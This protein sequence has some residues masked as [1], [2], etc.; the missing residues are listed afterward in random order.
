MSSACTQVRVSVGP[1]GNSRRPLLE[2]TC[3]FEEFQ[4][5]NLLCVFVSRRPVVTEG[6]KRGDLYVFD[7][8]MAGWVSTR[9][10]AAGRKQRES[11]VYSSNLSSARGK[12]LAIHVC[13]QASSLLPLP[14]ARFP[15][16]QRCWCRGGRPSPFV[17]KGS[18]CWLGTPCSNAGSGWAP[19]RSRCPLQ[20]PA[21]SPH[22]TAF[23][24]WQR[25]TK[26]FRKLKSRYM[27][28]MWLQGSVLRKAQPIRNKTAF[29]KLLI[30][31]WEASQKLVYLENC[32]CLLYLLPLNLRSH[33]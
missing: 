5:W 22:R 13:V 6:G 23:P 3:H 31:I 8:H 28:H 30:H 33:I 32:C 29:V 1:V 19:S 18:A 24:V 7:R 16:C 12:N 20:T 9:R 17:W 27:P 14:M 21:A 26:A 15:G 4:E 2:A 25:Q 10:L 11:R